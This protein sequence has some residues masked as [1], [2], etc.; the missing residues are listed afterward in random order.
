MGLRGRHQA[1][2]AAIAAATLV[3]LEAAEIATVPAAA[4]RAG[5]ANAVWPGRLEL[6][7]DHGRNVLLD[8]A[9]GAGTHAVRWT[10]VPG[11]P[12]GVY[13]LVA[14]TGGH[15]EAVAVTLVR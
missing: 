13:W 6:V 9:H 5:F 3:A 10:P 7:E 12:A 14:Q 11:V 8:G 4:R 2:N 15:T 1:A